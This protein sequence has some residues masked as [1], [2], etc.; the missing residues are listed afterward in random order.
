M[1]AV[2]FRVPVDDLYPD[3]S[4]GF[5]VLYLFG[6]NLVSFQFE[7]VCIGV[8][9]GH[10]RLVVAI[11]ELELEGAERHKL[12]ALRPVDLRQFAVQ[13]LY[14]FILFFLMG[15]FLLTVMSWTNKIE[16]RYPLL[17]IGD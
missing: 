3:L 2:D 8:E 17:E 1:T 11:H 6:L 10:D 7:S 5:R 9:I 15:P 4:D 16:S 13:P 12:V 14:E